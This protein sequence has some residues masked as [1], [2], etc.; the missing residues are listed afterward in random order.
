[1]LYN[2]DQSKLNISSIKP[3]IFDFFLSLIIT[4]YI[5][6]IYLFV[7]NFNKFSII[8]T[9]LFLINNNNSNNNN[10]PNT[11][12]DHFNGKSKSS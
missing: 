4:A 6:L 2:E 7:L 11:S 10:N 1:M 12:N 8:V 3:A 5:S 9:H